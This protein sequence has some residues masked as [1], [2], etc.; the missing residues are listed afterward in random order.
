VLIW[1]KGQLL[2]Q[3]T[4]FKYLGSFTS[5]DDTCETAIRTRIGMAKDAIPN[6]QKELLTRKI[7]RS[8]KKKVVKTLIWSGL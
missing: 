1:I 6:R 8:L 7:S 2:E 5:E 4:K 3:V